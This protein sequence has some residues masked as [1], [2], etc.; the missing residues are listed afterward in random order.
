MRHFAKCNAKQHF[1]TAYAHY[2]N[3]SIEVISKHVQILLKALISELRWKKEHWPWLI[4]LVEHTLNDRPQTR[5][6]GL[7]PVTVMSGLEP[8]HP[9]DVVFYNPKT[10][11]ISSKEMLN[12]VVDKSVND[13]QNSL[14]IMHK[15]ISTGLAISGIK[16]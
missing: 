11:V 15:S 16:L 9:L 12:A 5:L 1:V 10:I 13:L 7:A 14:V 4:K 3:G 6:N 2:S 8:D